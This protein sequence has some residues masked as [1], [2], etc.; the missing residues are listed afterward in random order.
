[1]E[2]SQ[3]YSECFYIPSQVPLF[4]H[5]RGYESADRSLVP[6]TDRAGSG[7]ADYCCSEGHDRAY[8]NSCG[9]NAA[10]TWLE[11]WLQQH[12]DRFLWL[13]SVT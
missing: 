4:L 7:E 5:T 3:F 1:M 8:I 2:I 11:W 6:K 10:G 13:L 9:P 12:E